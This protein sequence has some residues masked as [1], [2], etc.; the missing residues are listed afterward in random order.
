MGQS[1]KR[2]HSGSSINKNEKIKS[3]TKIDKE[4][5]KRTLQLLNQC[6]KSNTKNPE[7]ESKIVKEVEFIISGSETSIIP[8][9]VIP[10]KQSK[11]SSQDKHNEQCEICDQGGDLLC[12]D[13]CTLVFHV[14]CVRPKIHTVPK[15]KWSCAYCIV[16]V[17]SPSIDLFIMFCYSFFFL[18]LLFCFFKFMYIF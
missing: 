10:K 14:A 9:E 6:L 2:S 12:C 4:M 13:T 16:D 3:S 11:S 7:L 5:T 8:E 18:S 1:K 15:G 17:I